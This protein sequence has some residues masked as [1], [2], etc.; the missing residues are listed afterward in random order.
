MIPSLLGAVSTDVRRYRSLNMNPIQS[1]ESDRPPGIKRL[2]KDFHRIGWI[3]FWVQLVLGFLSALVI[4]AAIFNHNLNLSR[5][6]QR[7]SI[8]LVLACVG[9]VMLAFAIYWCWCYPQVAKR[10][11]NPRHYPSRAQVLRYLRFGLMANV[12]GMIFT[13]V[14]AEWNVGMLLLRVLTLPQGAAVYASGQLIEPLDIFVIQ[15]KI[16]TIG[17]ELTGIIVALWLLHRVN[18]EHHSD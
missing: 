17:A 18:Q 11:Q 5:A 6:S 2:A 8:G 1:Y 14:A 4:L 10:L 7:S 15:A 9:L 16:N 13:V 12:A 3:G